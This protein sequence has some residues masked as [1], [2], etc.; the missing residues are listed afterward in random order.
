M[1]FAIVRPVP[2]SFAHALSA[3]PP[4]PPIQVARAKD[5]HAL[6]VEAL[7]A[8][9]LD[10][11]AA[12]ADESCPDSCFVEDTAIVAGGIAVATRPGA[13]SRR[14]EVAPVAT[15]LSR[16]LEVLPLDRG[17]LDGGD[18]LRLKDTV[19]VGRT[20]RTSDEGIAALSALLARRAVR[21]VPID[22]PRHVLHL[23]CVCSP[24]DDERVLLAEG[25]L[26][27]RLFGP[28]RVVMV[29]AAE[30]Y[31]ANV[32][33]HGAGALVAEGFPRTRELLER[34][35]FATHAVDNRELRKADSALTCLSIVVT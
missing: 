34:A 28:A 5:E 20:A 12:S 2:D 31:A 22:V 17:T 7:R 13:A 25:T 33:T 3:S 26:D 6:Y 29:P 24:L 19:F 32:V 18:C 21:V 23:K 4:E 16:H 15:L 27:P 30:A 35:G 1:P 11:H 8:L 10:V 9:G 14:A